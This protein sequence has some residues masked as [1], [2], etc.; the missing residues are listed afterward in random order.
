MAV[1]I[2]IEQFEK[3]A[4][5][6]NK[7]R[8]ERSYTSIAEH[9]EEYLTYKPMGMTDKFLLE[10]TCDKEDV[11]KLQEF[12]INKGYK[13]IGAEKT[14]FME[15]EIEDF[16]KYKSILKPEAV[17]AY[18]AEEE[19]LNNF[20][21]NP[22]KYKDATTENDVLFY[23]Y[24]YNDK[25]ETLYE[26]ILSEKEDVLK[27]AQEKDITILMGIA[28]FTQTVSGFIGFNFFDLD[29]KEEGKE[30]TVDFAYNFVVNIDFDN[31]LNIYATALVLKGLT[32]DREDLKDMNYHIIAKDY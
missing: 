3:K 24:P 7:R 5:L 22:K 21:D 16:H 4:K 9:P 8:I 11:D 26:F 6:S 25:I 1:D 13:I 20:L 29:E 19:K 31:P 28:G 10:I 23:L 32:N 18:E 30:I 17:L 2:K 27:F 15:R 14:F 12:F